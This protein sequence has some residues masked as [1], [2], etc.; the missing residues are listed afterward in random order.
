MYVN[1]YK[2]RY[3]CVCVCSLNLNVVYHIF[4][5][6][7]VC[8]CVYVLLLSILCFIPLFFHGKCTG[9]F[10]SSTKNSDFTEQYNGNTFHSSSYECELST[11]LYG[12]ED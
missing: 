4:V 11:N 9:K 10:F 2:Y 6:V 7:S 3:P 12:H 1:F 5:C 8:K